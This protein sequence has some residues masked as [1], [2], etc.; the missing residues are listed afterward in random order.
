V[1]DDTPQVDGMPNKPRILL[2]N[3]TCLDVADAHRDWLRTLEADVVVDQAFRQLS[4]AQ[5]DD[6]VRDADAVIGP[7]ATPLSGD[8]FPQYSRLR[9]IS[10]AASGYDSLDVEAAT[11]AGIVVTNAP[12]PELAEV[13]ADLTWGLLIAVGRQIPQHD[14]QIRAGNLNRGM[15][16]SPW[17]KT[18]GIVGLGM[19]GRAMARRAAG[20]EMSVIATTP[21]P[22]VDFAARNHIE[23]TGLDGVLNQSDFISLHARL[24]PY[25]RQMIGAR[26]LA[27]MKPTAFLINTARRELVDEDALWQALADG[28]LAGA[29]LD[30]P[31]S[32]P[33]SPLLNHSNVIFTPHLGNRAR[34]A[35][36]AVFRLAVQNAVD[37]LAGLLPRHIVNPQAIHARVPP[38]ETPALGRL[39][40]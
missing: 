14:S 7:P 40:A 16:V 19:V 17:R 21:H 25:N 10:F 31:P 28:Q 36:D 38:W 35:A 3:G 24:T 23:L 4:A 29:A 20:F 11:R 32:R 27:Q 37:V 2:L 6:I 34:T 22:D 15:G 33:D 9:V 1:F 13:V 12:A 5:L 26:E 30:D 18:L 39:D 8:N